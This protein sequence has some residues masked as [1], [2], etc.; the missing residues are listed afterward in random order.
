MASVIPSISVPSGKFS[1]PGT[2]YGAISNEIPPAEAQSQG[3]HDACCHID[4]DCRD[5][6]NSRFLLRRPCE[7]SEEFAN[8]A[9][10]G[11]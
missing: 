2:R 5:G 6:A 11:T 9:L 4:F 1:G 8:N 3:T 10:A 7:S